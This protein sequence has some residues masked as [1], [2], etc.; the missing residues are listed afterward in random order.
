MTRVP[1][2][3]QE[4]A[5]LPGRSSTRT[6][7]HRHPTQRDCAERVVLGMTAAL[8]GAVIMAV[9]Y[10]DVR[11]TLVGGFRSGTCSTAIWAGGRLGTVVEDLSGVSVDHQDAGDLA[12]ALTAF[13]PPDF[14]RGAVRP[15]GARFMP[16]HLGPR[17]HEIAATAEQQ[18]R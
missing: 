15:W 14:A 2:A 5:G 9:G 6:L 8:P 4:Q 13:G 12:R 17:L 3:A 10:E 18:S 11:L 16:E 1:P 7:T